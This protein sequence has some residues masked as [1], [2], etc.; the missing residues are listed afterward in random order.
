MAEVTKLSDILTVEPY[1]I[2]EAPDNILKN[3][4]LVFTG[5]L[6]HISRDEAKDIAGKMGA[7]VSSAVSNKTDYVVLGEDAGSKLSKAKQLGIT[8]MTEDEWL[9]IIGWKM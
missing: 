2:S 8:V 6:L 3:K 1:K 5:K 4:T 7:H 9:K